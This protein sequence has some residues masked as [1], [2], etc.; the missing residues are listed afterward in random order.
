[1]LTEPDQQRHLNRSHSEEACFLL[2][3]AI[4]L[5][6]SCR[7]L[8]STPFFFF[9]VHLHP[10][11]SFFILLKRSINENAKKQKVREPWWQPSGRRLPELRAN[12]DTVSRIHFRLDSINFRRKLLKI[13]CPN[14]CIFM[15]EN[16]LSL[17]ANGKERK[18]AMFGQWM[19]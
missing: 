6:S 3:T 10:F 5:S 19:L 11:W 7:L 12:E 13:E 16:R 2:P 14:K 17:S 15:Y 9:F 4:V 1:M 8:F 18:M